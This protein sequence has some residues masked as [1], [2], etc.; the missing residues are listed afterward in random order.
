MKKQYIY[1]L[2]VAFFAVLMGCES[3]NKLGLDQSNRVLNF[4]M[5]AD[6]ASFNSLALN[7]VDQ[8]VTFTMYSEGKNIDNV[9]ILTDFFQFSSQTTTNRGVLAQIDGSTITNDGTTK[10]TLKLDDFLTATGVDFNDLAGGDVFKIYNIVELDNGQVYPDT[11]YIDTDDDG[12]L[13]PFLNI[14][15]S[16]L[17][18]TSSFIAE[19]AF[20][21]VCP[22]TDPFVGTY[23]ITDD[24]GLW[25]GNVTLT[26]NGGSSRTF[27][28]NWGKGT[29]T[30]NGFDGIGFDFDLVCGSIFVAEQSIGLGC[31][32][33][34]NVDVVTSS[35]NGP[36]IY[37]DLDDSQFVINVYYSNGDCF[38][39]FESILTF[40]KL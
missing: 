22:V 7:T 2:I 15:N 31:G 17:G 19:L 14:E 24:Q 23:A 9:T 8:E 13:D 21:I 32:G 27:T 12:D 35:V 26:T 20:P 28:G 39:D 1:F 33:G 11:V 34:S 18:G 10:L 29:V 6:V 5:E 3:D 4:R 36:G 38:G 25:L 30:A 40:D 37:D 16:F